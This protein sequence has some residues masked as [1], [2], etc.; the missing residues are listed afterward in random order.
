MISAQVKNVLWRIAALMLLAAWPSAR[1]GGVSD[2]EASSGLYPD[3][4]SPPYTLYNTG[5]ASNTLGSGYLTMSTYT[6][7]TYNYYVQYS[8]IVDTSGSFYVEAGVREISGSTSSDAREPIGIFIT[9]APGVGNALWI[10]DGRVFLLSSVNTRG[11]TAYVP[12]S[13]T[14]HTYEIDVAASGGLTVYDDGTQI[15]TGNTF[16]SVSANGDQERIAWGDGTESAYGTSEWTFV[17]HDALAASVPEPSLAI[18]ALGIGWRCVGR[19]PPVEAGTSGESLAVRVPRASPKRSERPEGNRSP[20]IFRPSPASGRPRAPAG[21][22][23]NAPERTG[24][25]GHFDA[26]GSKGIWSRKRGWSLSRCQ[27]VPRWLDPS[28]NVPSG[29]S[30]PVGLGPRCPDRRTGPGCSL[31]A[32]GGSAV[33][34]RLDKPPSC[35]VPGK[36]V[37]RSLPLRRPL[38]TVR[39]VRPTRPGP[40]GPAWQEGSI[41]RRIRGRRIVRGG[42][43]GPRPSAPRRSRRR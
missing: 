1:A 11:P 19:V 5:P 38:R 18:S 37:A 30:R 4:I 33:S 36:T 22:P 2:W 34:G 20:L 39:V 40:D 15:L 6:N 29:P 17:R 35:G 23:R 32:A 43:S 28:H 25:K 7:F 12:T 10:G 9:T 42:D 31:P 24:K 21:S 8:P 41:R 27:L 16:Y 26:E 14:F 3:Q 13:D